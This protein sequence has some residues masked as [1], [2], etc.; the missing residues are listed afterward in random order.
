MRLERMLL[1]SLTLKA[2]LAP[3]L[4]SS[5]MASWI[6]ASGLKDV[7]ASSTCAIASSVCELMLKRSSAPKIPIKLLSGV[8][9]L[10]VNG[11]AGQW[12]MSSIAAGVMETWTSLS[13]T[14]CVGTCVRKRVGTG[15]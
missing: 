4:S 5:L 3:K 14:F 7:R 15:G 8:T 2:V 13:V 12:R 1:P 6:R 10:G 9:L 11:E